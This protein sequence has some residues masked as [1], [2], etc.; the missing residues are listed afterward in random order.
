MEED[1]NRF[2]A[3]VKIN[4]SKN[5]LVTLADKIDGPFVLGRHWAGTCTGIHVVN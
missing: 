2:T 3:D 1:L 5:I 4:T